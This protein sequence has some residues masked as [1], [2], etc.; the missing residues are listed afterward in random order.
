MSEERTATF[1][2]MRISVPAGFGAYQRALYFAVR[3][4]GLDIELNQVGWTEDTVTYLVEEL[5]S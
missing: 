4:F 5:E 3:K 1:E 2:G